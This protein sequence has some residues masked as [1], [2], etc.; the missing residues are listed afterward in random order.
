MNGIESEVKLR[1]GGVN[2]INVMNSEVKME[3]C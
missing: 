1:W 2:V 3:N